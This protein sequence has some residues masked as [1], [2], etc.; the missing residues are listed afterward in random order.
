MDEQEQDNPPRRE[1]LLTASG[2]KEVNG[3]YIQTSE[4]DLFYK[5]KYTAGDAAGIVYIITLESLPE[6]GEDFEVAWALQS[7]DTDSDEVVTF[8]ATPCEEPEAQGFPLIG[9]ITV[10]GLEPVPR[11][12][13]RPMQLPRVRTS[14]LD[15]I[16]ENMERDFSIEPFWANDHN[17]EDSR[18]QGE[19]IFHDWDKFGGD[20][21]DEDW[22]HG[23][24]DERSSDGDDSESEEVELPD[25]IMENFKD[26]TFVHK[27]NQVNPTPNE[28]PVALSPRGLGEVDSDT[29]ED[30]TVI[31]HDLRESL[32]EG[33]ESP[34]KPSVSTQP[35][36]MKEVKE[37]EQVNHDVLS[38]R[39][40]SDSFSQN[41]ES[42][43]DLSNPDLAYARSQGT[44]GEITIVD[45]RTE[46]P[47][48]T[49]ARIG[50]SILRREKMVSGQEDE[51]NFRIIS[52]RYK[53]LIAPPKDPFT[54]ATSELHG[55]RA[56]REHV[57]VDLISAVVPAEVKSPRQR[58]KSPVNRSPGKL[59]TSEKG[60]FA[61]S[62]DLPIVEHKEK[63]QD[64]D[65]IETSAQ[66]IPSWTEVK[67]DVIASP[68]PEE[69]RDPERE[70]LEEEMHQLKT[71]MRKCDRLSKLRKR[72]RNLTK[73]QQE[74]L[75]D[76][77]KYQKRIEELRRLL[78]SDIGRS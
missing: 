72:G 39:V 28:R 44:E 7:H 74:T 75:L 66:T 20:D 62:F 73:E 40:E 24:F 13:P 76:K 78:G 29:S 60:K 35:E 47:G 52:P 34:M 9:W 54:S 50:C 27:H 21:A 14:N 55:I 22:R 77:S 53:P 18:D 11:I 46:P 70:K 32:F 41:I 26:G 12:F 63:K 67:T 16:E 19:G 68:K 59:Q 6:L 43:V 23:E 51:R 49:G 1:C 56:A 48:I 61:Q 58:V 57:D 31:K 42:T 8:Y 38:E 15:I 17:Q 25:D 10:S 2:S 45:L 71:K 37:E 3:S 4:E 33:L 64:E 36:E 5:K 65:G 30:F 69:K